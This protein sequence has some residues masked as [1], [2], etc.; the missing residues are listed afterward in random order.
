[1]ILLEVAV[2]L[3]L[4]R[5]RKSRDGLCTRFD[6]EAIDFH[7]MVGAGYRTI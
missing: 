6:E 4:N 5:K 7:R 3:G 1:M 2:T